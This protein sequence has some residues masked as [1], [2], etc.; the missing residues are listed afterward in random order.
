MPVDVDTL[1]NTRKVVGCKARYLDFF[2]RI[3]LDNVLK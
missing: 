1:N 3:V 2:G